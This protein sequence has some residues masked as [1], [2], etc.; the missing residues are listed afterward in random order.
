M[1]RSNVI[2]RLYL[3]IIIISIIVISTRILWE[4]IDFT[5]EETIAYA[6]AN[7]NTHLEL[8]TESHLK[9][10]EPINIE[11]VDYIDPIK[12]SIINYNKINKSYDLYLV[13]NNEQT[14][15]NINYLRVLYNNKKYNLSELGNM[16]KG[17][18]TYYRINSEVV[19]ASNTNIREIK[20]FLDEN[21][22]NVEQDKLLVYNFSVI[23]L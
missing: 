3:E 11:Q 14:K 18:Y 22:P 16:Q 5:K 21:I 10:L 17:E 23:D 12:L 13:I 6:Y 20:L 2:K 7:Y 4:N 1:N 19:S 9:S 8:K 15:L